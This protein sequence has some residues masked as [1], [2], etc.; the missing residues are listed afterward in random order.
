MSSSRG[1]SSARG[2]SPGSVPPPTPARCTRRSRVRPLVVIDAD[3]LGRQRTGD[4]TYVETSS[5][6]TCVGGDD[7][8]SQRSPAPRLVPDGRRGDRAARAAPGG[9][10]GW[11][12]PRLL[13]GCDPRSRTS[14]TPC[15]RAARPGRRHRARPLLRARSRRRWAASTA[16]IFKL[17]VPR[18]A[19]RA[20]VIAVS[21]RTK[22]DL[23]L[24]GSRPRRSPSRRTESTRPSAGQT[25]PRDYLLYVGA[26]QA[27]KDPLAAAEAARRSGSARRRRARSASPPSRASS[28]RRASTSAA[29]SRSRARRAL[30]RRGSPRAAVSFRGLRP[31]GARGDGVGTPVVA[32]RPGDPRGRG[33]AAVFAGDDLAAA[34]R[35]RRREGPL[36]ARNRAREARSAGRDRAADA[37]GYR[38]GSGD[39]GRRRLARPSRGARGVAAR[40]RAAGGRD[41]RDREHPGSSLPR[42]ARAG[43]RTRAALVRRQ[44]EPRD[45]RGE[46]G[47]RPRQQ[48]R[49]RPVARVPCRPRGVHGASVRARGSSGRGSS[50][51][52]ARSSTRGADFR[53]S[54]ARSS[55]GRR[56]AALPAQER[57][58]D[59]YNLDER[60]TEPVRPT[61]C[62]AAPAPPPRDARRARRLR[63]RLP[64][65]R[66]GDRPLLPR[67]E[68]RLGALVR[69]RAVVTHRWDAFTDKRFLTRRR[70]GTGVGIASA[71]VA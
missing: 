12:V 2:D 30:P 39:L 27:R 41:R 56:C 62:S 4:E 66:R 67:R 11:S 44:P 32:S 1:A 29:T 25:G 40:A 64:H 7:S 8:G 37:R 34:I 54:A 69:A 10:H 70:S 28:R 47:P 38:K 59:H 9:A 17:A 65:V 3:V 20:N 13:R 58:R 21:E 36:R 31:A 68:G 5:P 63:R 43:S 50:T 15:P 48:P 71:I 24:Y 52:T 55:A 57:Q 45:R 23:E 33:R 26:I 19:A 53:P 18:S 61:G 6:A 14:S 22:R 49:R 46:G 51:P 42:A 16:A 60:P 35:R